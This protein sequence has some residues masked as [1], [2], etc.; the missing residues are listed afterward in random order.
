VLCKETGD[1][2][3]LPASTLT[4]YCETVSVSWQVWV[5]QS[6]R[7]SKYCWMHF[8][9]IHVCINTHVTYTSF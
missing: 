5:W 4:S 2:H 6:W 9:L 3:Q 1:C 7:W 8:R